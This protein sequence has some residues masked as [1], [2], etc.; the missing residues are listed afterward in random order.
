[1]ANPNFTVTF[2][3]EKAYLI[4]VPR[5]QTKSKNIKPSQHFVTTITLAMKVSQELSILFWLRKDNLNKESKASINIRITI[6]G[7]RDGFSLGYLVD[8]KKFDRKAAVVAGR[9]EE[10]IQINNQ[11]LRVKSELMRH[12]NQLK[13]LGPV[14]TPLMLKNAYLGVHQEKKTLLQ[15]V[16]FHNSRFEENVNAGLRAPASLTKWRTTKDKLE[17]FLKTM[18]NVS[19]YPLFKIDFAFAEDL[20]HFLTVNQRIGANT[21]MK[22]IKHTK[23]LLKLAVRRR[24]LDANPLADFECPYIDPERHIL[25]MEELSVLYHK[26]IAIPRLEEAKDTYLFMSLTGLAYKDAEQLKP[27][28]VCKFFDSEDWI[29]KNRQKTWCRENV[30]LLPIAKEIIQKY[31]DHPYC[32]ANNC[33]LP[34]KSNQR[35][36]A[37]LKEIADICGIKKNLTTHTARHTFATT[38]TLANGVPVETVSAMLG[39]KSIK[40][41]QIYAKI[42]ASK[43]SQDMKALKEILKLTLPASLLSSAA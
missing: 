19:D 30:P 7:E 38:V 4:K 13:Q 28:H 41:T 17:S 12:Y 29:V 27:E 10:A 15:V 9:S 32:I 35:F 6:D 42:V 31:K 21:A 36:N 8:P 33:L 43:V 25:N 2:F 37:Y 3:Y 18:Y 16:D 34:I 14:V 20:H 40:T 23:Q 1:M 5:L 11:I 39:H 22:Y 24:W 26:K